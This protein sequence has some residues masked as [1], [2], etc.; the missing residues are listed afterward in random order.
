M[1]F[2]YFGPVLFSYL[3]LGTILSGRISHQ[4]RKHKE[5]HFLGERSIWEATNWIIQESNN[6]V[7]KKELKLLLM[8]RDVINYGF[9]LWI[10]FVII[11]QTI[12]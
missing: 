4:I 2:E 3:L 1:S 5:D 8:A 11:V 9:V 12:T 6:N 7:L 10:V